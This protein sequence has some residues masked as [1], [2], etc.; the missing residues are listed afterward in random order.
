M[1]WLILL[2]CY[3]SLSADATVIELTQDQ[4]DKVI[5]ENTSPVEPPVE[6]PI[7]PDP[8]V[9]PEPP[10]KLWNITFKTVWR[11]DLQP[12]RFYRKTDVGNRREDGTSMAILLPS[13]EPYSSCE[14]RITDIEHNGTVPARYGVLSERRDFDEPYFDSH[15]WGVS[16]HVKMTV[17]PDMGGDYVYF[18]HRIVPARARFA[19]WW[20]TLEA[21]FVCKR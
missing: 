11:T 2:L 5:A 18:N 20:S 10:G 9:K 12:A 6:P 4:I 14:L 15:V 21:I 17:T 1:R 19:P 3:I 16:G 7:D 13:I 8:P